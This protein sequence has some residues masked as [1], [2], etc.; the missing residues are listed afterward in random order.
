M[1][2]EPDDA[3]EP[4]LQEMLRRMMAGGGAPDTAALAR[5]MGLPGGAAGLEQLMAQLRQAMANP[6]GRIDWSIATEQAVAAAGAAT[7]SATDRQVTQVDQAFSVAGLWLDESTAFETLPDR[8]AAMTRTQ[9]I[10]AT[11]PFWVQLAEPVALRIAESLTGV[12][13]EQIP[14]E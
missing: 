1:A 6:D 8:P 9:W 7:L 10:R 5:A 12:F 4:D 11:M 3:Q 13:T 2:D 14:P